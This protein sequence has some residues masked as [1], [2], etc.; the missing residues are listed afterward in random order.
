MK[1][2]IKLLSLVFVLALMLKSTAVEAKVSFIVGHSSGAV[3]SGSNSA[4]TKN[5]RLQGYTQKCNLSNQ[6]G[7]GAS[8]SDSTGVYYKNCS[9]R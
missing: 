1:N 5:C 9:Y 6:Y 2:V 3:S 8:C 7:Q 4:N